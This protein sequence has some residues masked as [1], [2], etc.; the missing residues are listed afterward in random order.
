MTFYLVVQDDA[1]KRV[2]H[3][4][5]PDEYVPFGLQLF[6]KIRDKLGY[7][8]RAQL[9]LSIVVGLLVFVGLSVLQVKY[10]AVL[11]L[12]AALFEFIPYVGPVLAAGP[13]LILAFSQGGPIDFFLVL[14]LYIVIQQIENHFLIPKVMQRAVGLNPIVSILAIL[15]GAR[16]AG[17]IGALIA[18]PV[19]TALGVFFREMADRKKEYV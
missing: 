11:A 15:I 6:K 2:F 12:F 10:A 7:W 4:I 17:I 1:F 8:L 19:A 16:I 9:L 14:T 5:I 13:A 3:S 18:I